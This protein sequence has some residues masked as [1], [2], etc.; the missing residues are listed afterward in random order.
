MFSILAWFW[1]LISGDYTGDP[2]LLLV[3]LGVALCTMAVTVLSIT[4]ENYERIEDLRLEVSHQLTGF[5][6][7]WCPNDYMDRLRAVLADVPTQPATTFKVLMPVYGTLDA[8]ISDMR[9]LRRKE[10]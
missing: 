4:R 10:R 3:I 5:T 2:R 6:S 7:I 9:K 1:A 8:F